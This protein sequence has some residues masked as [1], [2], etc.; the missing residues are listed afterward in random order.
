MLTRRWNRELNVTGTSTVSGNLNGVQR[1]LDIFVGGCDINWNEE[2]IKQHCTSIGL[3]LKK[4]EHRGTK[5]EWD[6]AYK[7]SMKARDR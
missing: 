1:I 2:G 7:I 4:I 5:C 6:K 3:G